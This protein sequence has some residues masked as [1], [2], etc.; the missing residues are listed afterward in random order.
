MIKTKT[1][2]RSAVALPRDRFQIR[3]ETSPVDRV[4]AQFQSYDAATTNRFAEQQKTI[5]ALTKD[6]NRIC[7]QMAGDFVNGI[8]DPPWARSQAGNDGRAAL[9]IGALGQELGAIGDFAKDGTGIRASLSIGSDPD[10]GYVVLPQYSQSMTTKLFDAVTMRRLARVETLAIGEPSAFWVGE[11]ESRPATATPKMGLLTVPLQ[12]QYALQPV[13]Q[14]LLDM[15]SI[16]IGAWLDGKITD[17]FGRT[18]NV[19]FLSGDGV[20]K[21][22]G[23]LSVPIVS[24]ADATRPWGSI[25][26]LP[27]GDPSTITADSLKNLVV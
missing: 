27:S 19:S 11:Q 15:S 25:Q 14:S 13:T 10:G 23:I 18:E 6:I 21:D 16:D 20:K 4:L 3:A 17:K 12:E 9:N 2:V 26:Y 7:V 1:R 24:T 5:E 8:G 22:V